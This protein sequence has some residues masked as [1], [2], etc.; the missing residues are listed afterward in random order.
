MSAT[1]AASTPQ[2]TRVL[3]VSTSH[4]RPTP[5]TSHSRAAAASHA[6]RA[7]NAKKEVKLGPGRAA[8]IK[9]YEDCV[10]SG[11]WTTETKGRYNTIMAAHNINRVQVKH[12]LEKH[13]AE[14]RAAGSKHPAYTTRPP[15]TKAPSDPLSDEEKAYVRACIADPAYPVTQHGNVSVKRLLLDLTAA[16]AAAGTQLLKEGPIT[17]FVARERSNK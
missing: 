5:K 6:A 9:L 12:M 15:E 3:G 8:V 4:S 16:R 17:S 11:A 2:N 7:A 13:K 10:K 14:Q 1:H